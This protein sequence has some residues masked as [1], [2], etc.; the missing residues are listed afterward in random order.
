MASQEGNLLAEWQANLHEMV[1]ERAEGARQRAVGHRWIDDVLDS[2]ES[3]REIGMFGQNSGETDALVCGWG[4][5]RD[6]PAFIIAD[7]YAPDGEPRT[8]TGIA[9]ASRIQ[10]LAADRGT[11]II[12]LVIRQRRDEKE[13]VGAELG[14]WGF[15]VDFHGLRKLRN[16]A[17]RAVVIDGPVTAQTRMDCVL[18]DYIV[19]GPDG[20]VG[21]QNPVRPSAADCGLHGVDW[22]TDDGAEAIDRAVRY[23]DLTTQPVQDP[24]APAPGKTLLSTLCDEGSS[25]EIAP[26]A[27]PGLDLAL[28]RIDGVSVGVI[29]ID[30]GNWS[31]DTYRRLESFIRLCERRGLSVLWLT[32]GAVD[33]AN[34]HPRE[35]ARVCRALADAQLPACHLFQLDRSS[36]LTDQ[37]SRRNHSRLALPVDTPAA[38]VRTQ[39]GAVFRNAYGVG[40]GH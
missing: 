23:I 12:E 25:L 24:V 36:D 30:E 7:D 40:T 4:M 10:Q 22:V 28:C 26:V 29:S 16:S 14:I 13:F 32:T 9:K 6:A 27:E 15:G 19:L 33:D 31:T 37:L 3:F 20:A 18:A 1:E 17:A 11:P 34:M 35:S 21:L 8:S 2:P 38:Q 5:L 39:V